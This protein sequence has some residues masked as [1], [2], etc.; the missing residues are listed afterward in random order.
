MKRDK[1]TYDGDDRTLP[2]QL[3]END[4]GEDE[5]NEKSVSNAVVEGAHNVLVY[6]NHPF[7]FSNA[8]SNNDSCGLDSIPKLSWSFCSSSSCV[9]LRRLG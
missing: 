5:K 1:K 4:V 8:D 6:L 3:L 9:E 7:T 2:N